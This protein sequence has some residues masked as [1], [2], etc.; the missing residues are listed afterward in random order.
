MAIKDM[1]KMMTTTAEM[2]IH[3]IVKSLL[4]RITISRKQ[5]T[6][7]QRKSL[8]IIQFRIEGGMFTVRE[9]VH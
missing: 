8:I 1:T 9:L 6:Y 4:S 5:T 2:G 3:R 7:I